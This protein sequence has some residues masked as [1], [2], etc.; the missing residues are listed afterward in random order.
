MGT[1]DVV[2]LAT[3][4]EKSVCPPHAFRTSEITALVV[5]VYEFT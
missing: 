2:S 3:R 1:R 4:E 5:C